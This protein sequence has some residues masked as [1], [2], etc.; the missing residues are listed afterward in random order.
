MPNR[1]LKCAER[2]PQ[3]IPPPDTQF[4]GFVTPGWKLF[5]DFS[6]NFLGPNLTSEIEAKNGHF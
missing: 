4:A 6:K 2:V 3:P 1:A 5:L